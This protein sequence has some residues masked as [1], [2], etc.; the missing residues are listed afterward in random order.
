MPT[1]RQ[2][3]RKGRART[4]KK[5]GAPAL[6]WAYNSLKQEPLKLKGNIKQGCCKWCIPKASLD[7][8]ADLC[9][10]LAAPPAG[11][12]TGF[13]DVAAADVAFVA[14][15]EFN[16]LLG[17]QAGGV[18]QPYSPATRG[19]VAKMIYAAVLKTAQ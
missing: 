10:R 3:V 16:G 14:K 12:Q 8:I 19:E 18:F 7:E 5:T 4:H 6:R 17:G 2:L 15:A 13:T 1:I 9:A 11:Y